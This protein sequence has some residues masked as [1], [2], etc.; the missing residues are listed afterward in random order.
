MCTVQIPCNERYGHFILKITQDHFLINPESSLEKKKKVPKITQTINNQFTIKFRPGSTVQVS[1][2]WIYNAYIVV[3][4]IHHARQTA[5]L[6]GKAIMPK[7]VD[8][9]ESFAWLHAG[10]MR[11]SYP[12][13]CFARSDFTLFLTNQNPTPQQK[14]SK[15]RNQ[16]GLIPGRH[17]KTGFA[18]RARIKRDREHVPSAWEK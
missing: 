3:S 11:P 15:S 2:P 18:A 16:P 17:E 13:P 5:W 4:S 8:W 12:P 1:Y 14:H 10:S 7:Y 6:R 9:A